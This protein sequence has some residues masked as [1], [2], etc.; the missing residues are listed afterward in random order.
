MLYIIIYNTINY[1]YIYFKKVVE[2]IS[3]AKISTKTFRGLF[4]IVEKNSGKM[5]ENFSQFFSLLLYNINIEG[6]CIVRI[7]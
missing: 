2:R 7:E 5:V 4:G 1:N 6:N 3:K